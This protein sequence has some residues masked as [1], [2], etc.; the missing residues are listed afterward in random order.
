MPR[1][2]LVGRTSVGKTSLVQAINQEKLHDQKT[3]ATEYHN[4]FIDIPGEYLENP[5]FYNAIITMSY[6]V[7]I[8]ALVQD[9]N[10]DRTYFPPNFGDMFNIPVIGIITKLDL[11]SNTVQLER[12][13]QDLIQAGAKELYEVSNTTLKG[14]DQIKKLIMP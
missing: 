10:C 6:D 4:D 13:R 8:I 11:K 1:M 2:M 14:I 9:V 7:D 3:Q 12:T 5:R